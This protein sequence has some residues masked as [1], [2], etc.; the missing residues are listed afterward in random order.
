MY[1]FAFFGSTYGF[2]ACTA[3]STPTAAVVILSGP[4]PTWS[5]CAFV[6]SSTNVSLASC[7]RGRYSRLANSLILQVQCNMKIRKRNE[8]VPSTQKLACIWKTWKHTFSTTF[9]FSVQVARSLSICKHCY[10]AFFT[11]LCHFALINWIHVTTR[12]GRG[13]WKKL[14]TR[15]GWK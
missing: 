13:R 15:V 11:T 5:A 1:C 7:A 12:Q 14:D 3:L 2:P 9:V 4:C 6:R 8:W 10:W